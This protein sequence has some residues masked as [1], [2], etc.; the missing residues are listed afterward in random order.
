MV[1]Q[2]YTLIEG[3]KTLPVRKDKDVNEMIRQICYNGLK[4]RGLANKKEYV[5]RLEEELELIIRKEFSIYFIILW[6][7][8]RWCRNNG[9][10]V[11]RGRGSSAGSLVCYVM[12][13]TDVDPLEY[14]LLFWRFLSD[15]RADWPDID[16]DIADRDR[17]YLK[18]YLVEKYGEDK[19]ASVTTF[20]YFSA[21]SAFKAA[22]RILRVPYS[23]VNEITKDIPDGAT[24]ESLRDPAL[25]DFYLQYKGVYKLTKA[26]DGRLQT[27]GFHA[28]ATVITDK[29]ISDF[30]SL[31]SRKL[32][33]EEFRQPVIS[34]PKDDAEE[35][36]FIKY[37][38]LALK[39]LTVV[40]DC[41]ELV[42]RNYG[43]LIDLRH[44]EFT[45][46]DVFKMISSGDT[47]GVFQCEASAS[48]RV[49]KD[50]GIDSFMDLVASNA[51]V[52]PGAMKVMGKDYV[53]R[54]RGHAR[55]KFPHQDVEWF[56]DDTFGLVLY[57][58]QT[59]LI[60]T[61]LAGLTKE[62][63]DK[64]RKLTAK[65]KDKAELEPFKNKFIDGAKSK[66]QIADAEKLWTDIE[67]TAEYQF[68]KCLAEDTRIDAVRSWI[69]GP[70]E[71][72]YWFD[73]SIAEVYEM[74]KSG[75]QLEVLGPEYIRQRE[76]GGEKW[77]SIKDVHDN[78]V[79]DIVRVWIDEN[80]YIDST[81]NHKHRM[82]K[83][84]KE[85]RRIHQMDRIATRDGM[86]TVWKK[87]WEGKAQTYDLEL[88][89]EPHAFYANRIITHNSH[90]VA[91][92]QLSYITAMLKMYYPAEFMC[93]I[94][95]NEKDNVAMSNYL[96][97]C[98]RM[99][100]P[101]RIPDVN[102]SGVDYEVHDG[103]IYMGLSS[104]KYISNTLAERLI[105]KR[106]FVSYEDLSTKITEKDSGLNRRVLD[107]LDK[108]GATRF[109]DH[110]VDFEAC[111]NNF[112]EYI[113]IA[114]FDNAQVTTRMR[115][116]LTPL[117]EYEDRSTA[118]VVGIAQKIES[119]NGWTRV[120]FLD[121][122]GSK[123]FFVDKEHPFQKGRKYI[124]AV[125]NGGILSHVDL[126][127]FTSSNAI[128]RYLNGEF[129]EDTHL[130]AAKLQKTSKGNDK[131]TMLFS[132][133]GRLNSATAWSDVI[134]MARK[135]RTGDKVRLRV[136][137]DKKWGNTI[138]AIAKDNRDE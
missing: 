74:V 94:L 113:G 12:E 3:E 124:L 89:D 67:T 49:I 127:D 64:I 53:A 6:D 10:L 26:L 62:E 118:I 71:Y 78:N 1:Q 108:I 84:W 45:D 35:L 37:D 36:G 66:I 16:T 79:Q 111:K 77:Y 18:N 5:D 32:Q 107:S 72:F 30:V 133:K 34:I 29:N 41:I 48:T 57:Q 23:V 33:G 131:A 92:S 87:T 114:T 122:T 119:K 120:D 138:I 25:R 65:K 17:K 132:H 91:Y 73:I 115:E 137:S 76:A 100:I 27:V 58:E 54:K 69:D 128:V 40:A 59:M 134:P 19:V 14:N 136:K 61:E 60:C 47:V 96:A 4:K 106:P 98:K 2:A 22:C 105:L 43:K 31:E 129:V 15:W 116:R 11:G 102:K 112:F 38:F 104:I 85:A 68:N 123:G 80:R 8:I 95:M 110:P 88:Y 24:V 117:E 50:M 28:A 99:G 86:M 97:E 70:G 109:P 63:A 125:V 101:V 126:A 130:V 9:I 7:A 13:I 20:I 52:R 39:T 135:C 121:E 44:I 51:L 90:S 82:S 46:P 42:K 103:T 75:V 93:A 21:K 83:G 56:L 55:T 81:F